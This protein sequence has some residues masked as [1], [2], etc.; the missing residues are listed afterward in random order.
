VIKN[1]S[2]KQSVPEGFDYVQA[3]SLFT[4][5]KV[6]TKEEVPE[7]KWKDPDVDELVKFMCDENGFDEKRIRNVH[8]TIRSSLLALPLST[9]SLS[10]VRPLATVGD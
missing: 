1:L 8:L 4:H 3:R 7:L 9:L 5:P 10:R 2:E 6:L